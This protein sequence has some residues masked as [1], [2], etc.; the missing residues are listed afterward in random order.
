M[1]QFGVSYDFL[2][3]HVKELVACGLVDK[4]EWGKYRLV[5]AKGLEVIHKGDNVVRV[6]TH[7]TLSERKQLFREGRE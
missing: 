5:D 3:K 4:V 2:H 6:R 7:G 1:E